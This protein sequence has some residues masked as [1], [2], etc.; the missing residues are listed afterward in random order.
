MTIPNRSVNQHGFTI[1]DDFTDTYG[2]HIWVQESNVTTKPKV[3]IF[4]ESEG[5]IA[6]AHLDIAHAERVRDALNQWI[7]EQKETLQAEG[8][9]A[10]DLRDE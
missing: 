2:D 4:C 8:L 3:W 6:P 7:R 1:Y 5:E 9:A 10:A